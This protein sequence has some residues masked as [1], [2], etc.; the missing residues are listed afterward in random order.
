MSTT[1]ERS[2]TPPGARVAPG[3]THLGGVLLAL[4]AVLVLYQVVTAPFIPVLTIFAVLYAAVGVG[5]WRSRRRWLLLV[6]GLLAL[7]Y[8]VGGAP[9]FAEHLAHPESPLGFLTD[10]VILLGLGAVL[11]GVVRA[12]RGIAPAVHRPVVVG[13]VA[14]GGV[15]LVVSALAVIGTDSQA[16]RPGD[17][18]VVVSEWAYPDLAVPTTASALWIDNRDPF[19]HTLRVEGIGVRAVLPASTAVRVPLDVAPGTY[20]YFC[21]VPGHEDMSGTLRVH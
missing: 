2:T 5:L 8:L 18:E 4:A 16:H 7:A 17:V 15:A 9:V 21:D 10:V 13:A 1:L 6:A 3:D 12:L 14:I 19:H 20:R 11:V